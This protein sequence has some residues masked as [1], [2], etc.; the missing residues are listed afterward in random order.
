M[1]KFRADCSKCCGLCCVVPGQ[2]AMQGFGSDK[3]AETPCV[4][5]SQEC[6]CAIYQRRDNYGYS[7]CATFDCFGAGQFVTEHL[8]AGADWQDSAA[9]AQAMFAAYRRWL[10]R[11]HAAALIAAALPYVRGDTRNRLTDRM[12]ELTTNNLVNR[13]KE[14]DDRKLHR[15]TLAMIREALAAEASNV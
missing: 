5:L 11:F 15:E 8:F 1:S 6:R 14:A 3:S 4:H 7:A 12:V 10:P 2:L 9:L 13:I